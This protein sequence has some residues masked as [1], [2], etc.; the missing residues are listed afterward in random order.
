[1]RRLLDAYTPP[2]K[3]HNPRGVHIITDTTY[4]GERTNDSQWCVAVARDLQ[5]TEDLVWAF[6]D[7]ESTSLYSALRGELETL[8][9]TIQSVTGDG[10][11]GIRSAFRGIPFQMCQIHM[12]RI[13]TR[14]TTKHPQTEAGQILLALIRTLHT[15]DAHTFTQRLVKYIEKYRSFLNEKT[16]HPLGDWS[17]SHEGLRKSVLSLT[18]LRPFLFTFEQNKKIPKTT[19][20]L[21]GRFSHI[22]QILGDHRGSSR[23]HTQKLIHSILLAS[24]IAPTKKALKE[25]L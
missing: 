3:F 20:S 16:K 23:P 7:T 19:N 22:K 5:R 6:S 1:M 11:T 25:I 24:T 21:E 18:R 8:G 14:G 15:T 10:F 9:Y 13:V 17:W 4:F 12:E 2:E